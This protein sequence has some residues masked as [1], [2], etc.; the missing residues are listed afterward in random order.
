M[1]IFKIIR[2]MSPELFWFVLRMKS[3][4]VGGEMI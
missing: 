3:Y 1:Q 4:D 2:S